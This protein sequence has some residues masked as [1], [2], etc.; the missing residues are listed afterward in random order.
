M[1]AQEYDYIFMG[2]GCASLSIIVRMID[3]GKFSHKKILIIDKEE[4]NKNDRTWCFW[5]K[6]KNYFEP[7]VYKTWNHLSVKTD[8]DIRLQM[9]DYHYKMIR[10]ID[11]YKYCFDKITAQKNITIIYGN[12][13]LPNP[14]CHQQICINNIPLK[15]NKTAIVFNS[16]NVPSL[17]QPGKYHLLQHFKGWIIETREDCFNDDEATLMDFRVDQQYGTTFVYALP[18]SANNAL[19]EFTVFGDHVLPGSEYNNQLTKYIENYLSIKNFTI[20]EAESGIIPMTNVAFPF[21]KDGIYYIGT[22]GGQTKP[23]TGYTFRFIQKQADEIV[24]QLAEGKSSLTVTKTKK[25]FLFYDSTLL[26]ILSKKLLEGKIIFITLFKR[27]KATSIFKFL[28]NESSLMEE[29]RLL[30]TLQKKIFLKAGIKELLKMLL[31]R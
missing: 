23:S 24:R 21:C 22:A 15:I 16:I 7:V 3:S 26:H 14:G 30:N 18:L 2:A 19:I 4:K 8:V 27:N 5:E 29:A 1:D 12:V 25:R 11:F 9:Q 13:S 6:E 17:K 31:K 28:D 10:G 20:K